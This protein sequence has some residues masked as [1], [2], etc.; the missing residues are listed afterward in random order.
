MPAAAAPAHR[1]QACACA[2]RA[3]LATTHQVLK[4]AAV[5]RKHGAPEGEHAEEALD[6]LAA[7]LDRLDVHLRGA[8]AGGGSQRRRV[9]RGWLVPQ[10]VPCPRCAA[11]SGRQ[12]AGARTAM[13]FSCPLT[14][15]MSEAKA[16]AQR[17]M[18]PRMPA[19]VSGSASRARSRSAEMA[20][21][22]TL[23]QTT[24]GHASLCGLPALEGGGC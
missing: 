12:A 17:C 15:W 21:W 8:A 3:A 5:L 1:R 13:R 23:S 10:L 4:F 9:P 18:A 6:K 24:C 2:Q 22:A 19:S 7:A 11:R 16:A 14:T 20:D